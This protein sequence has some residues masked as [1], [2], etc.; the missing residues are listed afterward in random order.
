MQKVS[1]REYCICVPPEFDAI[2]LHQTFREALNQATINLANNYQNKTI[3]D[4]DKFKVPSNIFKKDYYIKESFTYPLTDEEIHKI[5]TK[6]IVN[7][8]D[9]NKLGSIQVL[10]NKK[11]IYEED[12][13]EKDNI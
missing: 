6:I 4:K 13:L 11:V 1:I 5:K 7:D 9:D 10:L 8:K 3:L 12:I 2:I